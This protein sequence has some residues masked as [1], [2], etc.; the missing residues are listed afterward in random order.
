MEDALYQK[1]WELYY[2]KDP[3]SALRLEY[4]WDA[5]DVQFC[6]TQKG[7][8]NLTKEQY[9]LL[10]F[11]H[12]PTG[13]LEE[14]TN[15]IA[16]QHER[17]EKADVLYCYGLGLGYLYEALLPW[18]ETNSQRHLVIFEDD[19][20]PIWAFF[21]QNRATSLLQHPQVTLFAFHEYLQDYLRLF[22]LHAA[23]PRK[24]IEYIALPYYAKRHP[25]KTSTFAY[26]FLHDA[27]TASALYGEYQSGQIGFYKNYYSNL[28]S[29]P[30][31]YLASGLYE[32][33]NGIPA[34]ICGAGPS[35]E[36][37][38]PLLRQLEE[39]ALIFA[40]SSAL[41]ALTTSGVFPHF[42]VGVDPNP[43]QE[44]RLLAGHAFALPF[45]Y[46]PRMSHSALKL[47]SGD[48]VF[49]P[50]ANIPFAKWV[51]EELG[52]HSPEMDEGHNV[53]NLSAQIAQKMGCNPIIFVGLD[54]SYTD[55]KSYTSSLPLHPLWLGRS[56]PHV[57]SQ[58]TVLRLDLFGHPTHTKWEWLSE[59]SWLAK[60]PKIFPQTTFLNAT[61][62][63]IGFPPIQNIALQ[64]IP[65]LWNRPNQDLRGVSQQKIQQTHLNITK[66]DL[67]HLFSRMQKEWKTIQENLKKLLLQE[68]PLVE[69][70]IEENTFFQKGLAIYE[71]SYLFFQEARQQILP[72][73][74]VVTQTRE[75]RKWLIGVIDQHLHFLQQAVAENFLHYSPSPT[76][77][78]PPMPAA[79]PPQNPTATKKTRYF[80]DGA[81]Y[82]QE[83]QLH[84]LWEGRQSFFFPDGSLRMVLDFSKG[85]LHGVVEIYGQGRQLVR[86][87]FYQEGKRHGQEKMWGPMQQL[88]M[89]CWYEE[90][91]PYGSAKEWSREGKL[92]KETVIYHFPED[93]DSTVFSEENAP[94]PIFRRGIRD[95][96]LF[97]CEK[98]A[99]VEAIWNQLSQLKE[100]VHTIPT[101][102]QNSADLVQIDQ[103]LHTLEQQR[104]AFDHM[105]AANQETA[106]QAQQQMIHATETLQK[107]L[108]KKLPDSRKR[109]P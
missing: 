15:Y 17:L 43:E 90:G 49:V 109:T 81:I 78:A 26:N 106:Q 70:A 3:L 16:S 1:N 65:L 100:K 56:N 93:F 48:L 51:E 25:Q 34:I 19:F 66:A 57:F 102:S 80:S 20:S 63:G 101:L 62:G 74:E 59:A 79:A 61:E 39:K 58:D 14:A 97:Y 104:I 107:N 11:Y 35:L 10:D 89:E 71:K 30:G 24:K 27:S 53:V 52:I 103:L 98:Q 44:H 72:T 75:R 45:L 6:H 21:F 82:S 8:V 67:I 23:F 55:T 77:L 47:V 64:Q 50:G 4:I 84:R 76:P 91:I 37:Q 29:L 85:A 105:V 33:F 12:A 36:K 69:A 83:F 96:S 22:Q 28:F 94:I 41:T 46:R 68:D 54:L 99:S 7:E 9:G 92:L 86:Q 95:Y 5:V 2:E 42:G 31:Q 13:A 73:Q 18:L 88:L 38:I 60:L 87:I 32:K 40:G 108:S